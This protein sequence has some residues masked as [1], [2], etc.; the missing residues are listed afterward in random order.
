[1]DPKSK[2]AQDDWPT[3]KREAYEERPHYQEV[4]I[5]KPVRPGNPFLRSLGGTLMVAGIAWSAYILVTTGG[6][7]N[8][9]QAPGPVLTCLAGIVLSLVAK[10]F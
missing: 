10:L 4:R 9:L 5:R 8:I 1:M 2:I 6:T 7:R 3:T